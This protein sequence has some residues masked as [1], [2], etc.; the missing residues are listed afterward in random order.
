VPLPDP[1]HLGKHLLEFDATIKTDVDGLSAS[2]AGGGA[3]DALDRP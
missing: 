2:L 3:A 1:E